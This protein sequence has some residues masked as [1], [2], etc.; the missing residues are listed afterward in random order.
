MNFCIGIF[1]P[2]WIWMIENKTIISI[3]NCR[4]C[5]THPKNI[6]NMKNI[7]KIR[8]LIRLKSSERI[9]QK[10]KFYLL[11]SLKFYCSEQKYTD[12]YVY[13]HFH[14]EHVDKKMVK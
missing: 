3:I 5:Y 2:Y 9:K 8:N 6:I 1:N 7:P 11:Q 4:A 12:I 13:I 10:E 14:I